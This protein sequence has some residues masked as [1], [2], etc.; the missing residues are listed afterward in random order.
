[1]ALPD[2]VCLHRGCKTEMVRETLRGSLLRWH[3]GWLSLVLAGVWPMLGLCAQA[4]SAG[5]RLEASIVDDATGE[6]LA[7][8]VAVTSAEGKFPSCPYMPERSTAG[9]VTHSSRVQT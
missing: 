8:R 6:P 4:P 1:M 3:I 5:A 7:A 9:K 2:R